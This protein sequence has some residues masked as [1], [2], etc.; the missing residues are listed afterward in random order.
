[1]SEI[2]IRRRQEYKRN[3]KKWTMIQ[4]VALVIAIAI[5]LV[6]FV[7]YHRVNEEYYIEYTEKG[8]VDYTVQYKENDFFEDAMLGENQEYI[9]SLIDSIQADF[10]YKLNMD[11]AGVGF[12]YQYSIVAKVLVADKDSGNPYYTYE[13]ILLPLTKGTS[14]Q[15]K[16]GISVK[17]SVS[18]NFGK[19]NEIATK[20]IDAYNLT[21]STGTLLVTLDVEALGTCANFEQ[22]NE[23]RYS[24]T[25]NVPLAK[26]TLGL[27]ITNGVP[28]TESKVLACRSEI[29]QNV[30]LYMGI[31]AAALA[32]LIAIA[33]V[34]F[35][36]LTVNDDITYTAKVGKLVRAYESYIQKIVGEFDD[37]TYQIVR[38]SSF[39]E[40][41]GI[42]DTIQSPILMYENRDETMTRFLIPTNTK[43]LYV[44]EIKVDNY[45]EIYGLNKDELAVEDE[46]DMVVEVSEVEGEDNSTVVEVNGEQAILLEEDIN[47]NDVVEAL[48]QPDV[49]LSEMGEITDIDDG[50]TVAENEHG[51]EV[52][53]V[54]WPEKSSRNKVYRYDPNGEQLNEGDMVLVPTFD[55]A[56]NRDVIKKVAVS[57]KNHRV[58]PSQ[59][60]HPLKKIIA[61]IKRR[62]EE[63]LTSGVTDDRK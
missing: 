60:K 24:I 62:T 15:G 49:I 34:V 26:E 7:I 38:I 1:M 48:E 20:F 61:I 31:V 17:E 58:D 16:S 44:F 52:I 19:Y 42:R 29:N 23:N 12:D 35:L 59:I 46:L 30:F 39:H 5:S 18:L 21:N 36:K 51:V 11:A 28:T 27:H 3:R 63:A 47:I 2:E 54:V 56:R 55:A 41:L 14:Q 32:F 13:E 6:S 43:I 37:S 9:A 4:I 40:M 33:L 8:N 10:S 45:D 22:S 57:H 53:G 50:L 25:L